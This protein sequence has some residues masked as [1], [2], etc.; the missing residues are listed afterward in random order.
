MTSLAAL[1]GC[2]K[3][4]DPFT[5]VY[6]S[7]TQEIHYT[8]LKKRQQTNWKDNAIAF[9]I[10]LQNIPT[11]RTPRE[12]LE[13]KLIL[14]AKSVLKI[15]SDHL[16]KDPIINRC[17][18][19]MLAHRLGIP[20]DVL[21]KNE[22]FA[23]F[24]K[25]CYLYNYLSAYGDSLS[26]DP[27]TRELLIKYKKRQIKWSQVP[28]KI[29]QFPHIERRNTY[30]AW[31]YGPNGLRDKNFYDFVELKKVF[32]RDP[33]DWG[34]RFL[35]G[36]CT[37]CLERPRLQAGDHSWLR[38]Y[39]GE[40]GYIYSVGLYRPDKKYEDNPEQN[41]LRVKAGYLMIDSSEFWGQ[42]IQE[43]KVAI[44]K[45]DFY[46][47]K[48]IVE[49]DK[50]KEITR[51]NSNEKLND[52]LKFQL[53]QSNC[54]A[55]VGKVTEVANIHLPDKIPSYTAFLYSKFYSAT[56]AR[57]IVVL[58]SWIPNWIL[59]INAFILTFITNLI[60]WR[61]GSSKVDPDLASVTE[62]TPTFSRWSQLIDQ[63]LI[64]NR[65]PF[66]LGQITRSKIEKWREEQIELV[67]YQ[68]SQ[69]EGEAR[70]ALLKKIDDLQ[71]ALPPAGYLEEA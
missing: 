68:L 36:I 31:K 2:L 55:Y 1:N 8:K 35:V 45:Q 58:K 18:Q 22:G 56:M 41:C 6:N 70:Q 59:K 46:Q 63:N 66:V 10:F 14:A 16:E 51:T 34:N 24:A 7:E 69:V 71:Y 26:F 23:A 27:E 32:R 49:R 52:V 61:Y 9:A 29:K 53:M 3:N 47:M 17:H 44:S 4:K 15:L 62:A 42:P 30:E 19:I 33:R 21:N 28:E 67:R 43:I 20:E 5:F 65:S 40:T 54:T 37:S 64:L 39:D 13:S 48:S 50:Q 25:Q 12:A 38:L 11:P 57:R 60:G